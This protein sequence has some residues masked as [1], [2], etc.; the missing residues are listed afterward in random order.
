MSWCNH[1]EGSDNKWYS[2]RHLISW[3]LVREEAKSIG[4]FSHVMSAAPANCRCAILCDATPQH[5]VPYYTIQ[6]HDMQGSVISLCVWTV[7]EGRQSSEICTLSG[8]SKG[9]PLFSRNWANPRYPPLTA[10]RRA[11]DPTYEAGHA[12]SLKRRWHYRL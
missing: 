9:A 3:N 1:W 10:V 4:T 7:A 8:A 6:W 2:F 5:D 11:C 12:R